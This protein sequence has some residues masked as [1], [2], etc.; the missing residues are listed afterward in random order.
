MKKFIL[1]LC[2][3]PILFTACVKDVVPDYDVRD[4]YVGDYQVTDAC[5]AS[6]NN[7]DLTIFKANDYDEIV[8]G[9]PGL[10]ETGMEVHAIVTGMKAVIPLQDFYISDFPEIFYE[11]SGSASLEGDTLTVDYTVLTV[12]E[13]LIIDENNCRATMIRN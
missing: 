13:G 9:W 8:F 6:F 2:I 1:G 10:Y 4:E 3:T 11:F 7:Y 12:Q 5:D